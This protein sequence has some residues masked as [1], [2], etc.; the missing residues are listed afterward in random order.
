[1]FSN[2][3][4]QIIKNPQKIVIFNLDGIFG[5][6]SNLED[7]KKMILSKSIKNVF[8]ILDEESKRKMI[9]LTPE[10]ARKAIGF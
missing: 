1:M 4:K 6:F 7:S 3:F 2:Y 9:L 10:M 8:D 5:I